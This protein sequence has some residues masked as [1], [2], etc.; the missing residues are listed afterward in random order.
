MDR[1]ILRTCEPPHRNP[2]G[3]FITGNSGRPRGPN[4]VNRTLRECVHPGGR[5]LGEDGR[6]RNGP[7]RW[8]PAH[9]DLKRPEDLRARPAGPLLPVDLRARMEEV[10]KPVQRTFDEVDADLAARGYDA[11][12]L[13]EM[14]ERMREREA[15]RERMNG[16]GNGSVLN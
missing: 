4:R 13:I 11:R 6:G 2:R 1:A 12:R 8:L 7:L 10:A 9:G 16:G 3:R 15:E 14:G 5:E